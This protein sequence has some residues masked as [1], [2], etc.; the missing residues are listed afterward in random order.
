MIGFIGT[1]IT[2]TINYNRLQQPT[3]GDC[4]RLA[5]FLTGLR[6]SSLLLWLNW[7]WFTNRSLVNTPQLYTQSQLQSEWL[8]NELVNDS[9]TTKSFNYVSS[10]YNSGRTDERPP[11]RTV[12]VLVCFIRCHGNVLTARLSSNGLFRVYSSLWKRV[13]FPGRPIHCVGYVPNE[14]C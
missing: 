11:P 8:T 7:L 9:G 13:L 3:I 6:A 1:F 14:P 5:Q 4:L 12:R 10:F 2:I